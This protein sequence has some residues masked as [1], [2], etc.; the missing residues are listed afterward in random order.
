MTLLATASTV[1]KQHNHHISDW[2]ENNTKIWQL[3][4]TAGAVLSN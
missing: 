1:I 3:Y 4:L 2:I